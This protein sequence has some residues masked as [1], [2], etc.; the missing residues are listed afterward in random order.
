MNQ[1]IKKLKEL[2]KQVKIQIAQTACYY[3]EDGNVNDVQSY[4]SVFHNN[5]IN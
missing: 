2:T 3:E 5:I 4:L 1:N